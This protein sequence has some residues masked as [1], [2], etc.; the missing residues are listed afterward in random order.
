MHPIVI[1]KIKILGLLFFILLLSVTLLAAD[2][3]TLISEWL[4]NNT[5]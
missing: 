2:N 4:M 1:P 5:L 3:L